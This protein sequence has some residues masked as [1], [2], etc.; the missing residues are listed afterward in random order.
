MQNKIWFAHCAATHTQNQ[1]YGWLI[2]LS[3]NIIKLAQFIHSSCNNFWLLFI[4]SSLSSTTAAR[5]ITL[6][7]RHQV[8]PRIIFMHIPLLLKLVFH[9]SFGRQDDA[10]A[11]S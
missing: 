8:H 3:N 6:H 2:L 10:S 7:D 4:K 11:A 9:L 1:L 5:Q